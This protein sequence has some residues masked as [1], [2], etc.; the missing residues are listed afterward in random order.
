VRPSLQLRPVLRASILSARRQQKVMRVSAP[1]SPAVAAAL[2]L[3]RQPSRAAAAPAVSR[4]ATSRARAAQAVAARSSVVV[5]AAFAVRAPF[6]APCLQQAPAR[7]QIEAVRPA[8]HRA[9]DV[10]WLADA[11]RAGHVPLGLR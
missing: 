2:P 11:A 7:R 1:A 10:R 5:S 3:R 8:P 9:A 4:P 6:H